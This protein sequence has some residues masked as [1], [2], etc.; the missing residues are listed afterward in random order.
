MHEIETLNNL[1]I[2]IFELNVYQEQ[3]KWKHEMIPNEFSQN[4]SNI[5]V[6]LLI[7]KNHYVLV[8]KLN[9]FSGKQ[10]CRYICRQCRNSY[11]SEKILIKHKQQCGEKEI[12][13][14]RTS[15]EA[16]LYRKIH[17]HKNPIFFRVHADFGADNEK[18]NSSIGNKTTNIYK[19]NPVCNGYRI[20]SE[21][22]IV[23][24][25]SY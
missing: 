5:A 7:Y 11:T 18:D 9:V 1:S 8:K 23:L 2:N 4:E 17:F 15:L 6:D 16:H 13:S 24:K 22:K 14:V 19:Q 21:L 10:D 20:V 25:S 12:S 3:N